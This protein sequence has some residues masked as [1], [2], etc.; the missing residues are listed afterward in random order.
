MPNDQPRLQVRLPDELH[1]RLI[2]AARLD[3]RSLNAEIVALLDWAIEYAEDDIKKRLRLD[4]LPDIQQDKERLGPLAFAIS[5]VP[6]AWLLLDKAVTL[7]E[8]WE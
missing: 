5:L 8:A 6:T 4:E 2:R 1:R 3:R 7:A